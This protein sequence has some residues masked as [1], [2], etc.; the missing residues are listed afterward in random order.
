MHIRKTFYKKTQTKGFLHSWGSQS[1][2]ISH[3]SIMGETSQE[4]SR[5]C[6]YNSAILHPPEITD[7]DG[8]VA[9]VHALL[10][11]RMHL[12]LKDERWVE[13]NFTAFDKFGNF[14]LTS[15]E[16]H[17]RDQTR[18][19]QMVI[20]PLHYVTGVQIGPVVETPVQES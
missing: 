11:R 9:K 3:V 13:G 2:F 15:A 6:E 16:E 7:P 14:V 20:V 8:P 4:D 10:G 18:K 19:M 1:F 5:P 12:T 17:F